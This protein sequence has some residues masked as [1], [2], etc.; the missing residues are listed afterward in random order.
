M[1]LAYLD[2]SYNEDHYWIAA[3]VIPDV[4]AAGLLSRLEDVVASAAAGL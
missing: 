1:L 4:G 3:L 2:E